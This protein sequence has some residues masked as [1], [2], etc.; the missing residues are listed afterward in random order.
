MALA[1]FARRRSP[2]HGA[3]WGRST[4]YFYF[5]IVF[6]RF[7]A[8]CFLSFLFGP[9]PGAR[10]FFSL[11]CFCAGMR[12]PPFG[13]ACES[14][15]HPVHTQLSVQRERER[16]HAQHRH[17]CTTC[18]DNVARSK[19]VRW[20]SPSRSRHL[21]SYRPNVKMISTAARPAPDRVEFALPTDSRL[22]GFTI[23]PPSSLSLRLMVSANRHRP[24]SVRRPAFVRA[25]A[26]RHV[27]IRD[28]RAPLTLRRVGS[29]VAHARTFVPRTLRR[30]LAPASSRR[31]QAAR[32]RLGSCD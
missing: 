20:A 24:S 26:V 25:P 18:Y 13:W 27:S 8:G 1:G 9:V 3:R 31:R 32:D 10:R 29:L 19:I 5:T 28:A 15:Q 4:T 12:F 2:V 16:D 22:G 30:P 17:T 11:F 21:Q 23:F 14:A 6:C 7:C